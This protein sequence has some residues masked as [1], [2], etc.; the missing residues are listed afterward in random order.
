[1][2]S[3]KRKYN[4]IYADPPWKYDRKVGQGVAED[5]YHTMNIEDICSLPVGTIAADDCVLFLWVT[6][7]FLTEGLLVMERSLHRTPAVHLWKPSLV[8]LL[9]RGYRFPN[10]NVSRNRVRNKRYLPWRYKSI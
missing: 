3:A 8:C 4:I 10:R 6:F 1:M 5:H 7:P 9:C 2:F